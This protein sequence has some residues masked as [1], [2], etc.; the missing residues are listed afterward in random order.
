[1]FPILVYVV[2]SRTLSHSC[3]L[4]VGVLMLGCGAGR[5]VP[6]WMLPLAL[7]GDAKP[8]PGFTVEGS[9]KPALAPEPDGDAKFREIFSLPDGLE[10]SHVPNPAE[11]MVEGPSQR[12]LTWQY[13]TKVQPKVGRVMIVE[14]GAFT[15][16]G[17]H[18]VFSNYTGEPF[19]Q[20]NFAQWYSCPEA[21][22]HEDQ[23][24]ADTRSWGGADIL[25]RR[26]G[27]WYYVGVRDVGT[28]VKGA[29]EVQELGRLG[30][31]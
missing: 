1:M 7:E 3:L 4:I 9:V 23:S 19:T 11:A 28:R 24:C 30:S 22:I 12:A 16:N 6:L 8:T 17:H 20:E 15:W 2:N 27:L 18:R 10:V 14:F 21:I 26:R 31:Q 13:E 29:A 5:G 25:E